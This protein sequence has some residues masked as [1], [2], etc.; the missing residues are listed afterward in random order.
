MK[1]MFTIVIA[2][3]AVFGALADQYMFSRDGITKGS[4][5]RE[6]PS[7]GVELATGRVVVGLH[8]LDDLSRMACGWY[9]YEANPQPDTNHY[10]RVTNYVFSATG[11]VAAVWTQYTPKVRPLC[12]SK[13]DILEKL[14]EM[15][16]W[17]D[18]KAAMESSGYL[19]RWNACT[20]IAADN[21]RF[22]A[23]KPA[24]AE[25]LGVTEKQLDDM[26]EECVYK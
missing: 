13:L 26:L 25:I 4:G 14:A 24:M 10:W 2:A 9:R 21:E 8:A 16:K 22:L 5:L 23:I 19:D 12:Y 11:T 7:Q 17:A 1:R 3:L 18:V 6:L 20:Y 15:G